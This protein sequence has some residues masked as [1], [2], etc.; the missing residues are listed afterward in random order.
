LIDLHTHTTASDGRC[1][2]AELVARAA[3]ARVD[4]LSV[5]DHDTTAA[6]AAASLACT[7]AGIHFVPGIE[8]TAVVDGKDVHVLGYFI[9]PDSV[10]L[11]A[12]L[13]EQRRRRLD[14]LGQI[15]DRLK[16]L[17]IVLDR[18]AVLQPGRDDTTKAAGRPWIARALVAGGHVADT[19]EAFDRFLATGKPAFVPRIGASPTDVFARIH[20][21]GGIA[22]L[23]HPGL[24]GRDDLIP[25]FARAGLDAIEAHHSRHT[26]DDTHRYLAMADA[27]G[28]AVSGGSDYHADPSHDAG[29]PGSVSL[30]PEAF[31]VLK[32]R[33]A[34]RRATA[35]GTATSS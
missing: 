32:D 11:A 21:S 25:G 15:L 31:Q 2:P 5:T 26:P 33:C 24:L 27:Y 13:A 17:G 7:S 19:K 10:S 34:A 3:A 30:S 35:S 9:A 29:G 1:S 4:V 6:T 18:E 20:E 12:F 14:R 22:S 16:M 28:L 23:A 8:I